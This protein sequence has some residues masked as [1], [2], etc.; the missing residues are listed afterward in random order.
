MAFSDQ[1]TLLL[2]ELSGLKDQMMENLDKV[3]ERDQKV[4]VSK[5]RA[6]SLVEQSRTY[7]SRTRQVRSAM[8]RRKYCYIALG[9][10]VAIAILLI[11]VFSIC[12]ITFDKCGNN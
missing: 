8:R 3:I 1:S 6:N 10:A 5:M 4:N 7:G 12:G 2:D 11:L 9:I